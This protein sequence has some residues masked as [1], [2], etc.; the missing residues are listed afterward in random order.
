MKTDV[1]GAPSYLFDRMLTPELWLSV[2][3]VVFGISSLI[4]AAILSTRKQEGKVGAKVAVRLAMEAVIMAVVTVGYWILVAKNVSL[5]AFL[6][7]FCAASFAIGFV[8]VLVNIPIN[9]LLMRIVDR[10]KLSKVSSIISIA[11]QGLIP[12]ASVLAG[13]V[14][15]YMGSTMMLVICSIGFAAAAI[16]LLYNKRVREL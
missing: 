6:A 4:G 3:E 2:I 14:L 5:N 12:V 8:L 9:T 16:P 10:D 15:Q 13:A 11:A 7:L 1:A